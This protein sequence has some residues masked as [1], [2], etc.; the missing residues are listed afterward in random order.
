M[1]GNFHPPFQGLTLFCQ[2]CASLSFIDGMMAW[3][4]P[5]ISGVVIQPHRAIYTIKMVSSRAG[6]LSLAL[7]AR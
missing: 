2:F 6:L 7:T 5:V 1:S 3:A 4:A